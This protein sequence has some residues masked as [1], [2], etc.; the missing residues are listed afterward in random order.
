MAE[1]T[2]LILEIC[3]D[4]LRAAGKLIEYENEISPTFPLSKLFPTVLTIS[5]LP[6]T[7]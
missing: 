4:A 7:L 2:S 5:P 1:K 6:L 3:F